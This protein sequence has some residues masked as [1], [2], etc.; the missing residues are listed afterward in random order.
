MGAIYAPVGLIPELYPES[1]A[2]I[3]ISRPG[4]CSAWQLQIDLASATP[5]QPIPE[6]MPRPPDLQACDP[7]GG[8]V[9]R[10]TNPVSP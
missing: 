10:L 7:W 4:P 3:K 9:D 1:T 6:S 5:M 2:G 8:W